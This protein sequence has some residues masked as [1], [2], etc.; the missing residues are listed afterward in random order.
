MI[1]EKLP[2]KLLARPH[3]LVSD[4]QP[5]ERVQVPL[6][7]I[8]I[9]QDL[10][11]YVVLKGEI[12][13]PIRPGSE[14]GEL[15]VD[16]QGDFHLTIPPNSAHRWKFSEITKLMGIGSNEDFLAKIATITWDGSTGS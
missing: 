13:L 8:H 15:R 9:G 10:T 16:D 7:L 14:Y 12:D 4:L 3:K 5:G 1:Y 11:A 2:E 6:Y